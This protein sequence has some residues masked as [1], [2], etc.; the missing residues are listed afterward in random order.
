MKLLHVD[1]S[2]LGAHSVSRELSAEIVAKM[3]QVTPGL[4]IAYRDLAA[5]P[6]P[7]LSG[8]TLAAQQPAAG[9]PNADVEHDHVLSA[10]VLNEF[11]AAGIVVIGAP[12]YNFAIASQLKAW[13]DRLL[14]A[15]KTFR[16]TENKVVGLAGGKRVIIASSRGGIYSEG[17]PAASAEHQETYLRSVFAFIGIPNI[18]VV[19]AEGV[20]IGPEPRAQAIAAAEREIANLKAA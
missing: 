3:R 9:Q 16:Y 5:E 17:T 13:I 7:H 2:I 12:M 11:L 14:I 15:G 1:S 18:E 10:K 20:A 19:R 4:E 6:V 8:S